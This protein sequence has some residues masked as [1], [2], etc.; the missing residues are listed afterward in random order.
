MSSTYI[1][2]S[3]DEKLKKKSAAQGE[4][5]TWGGAYYYPGDKYPSDNHNRFFNTFV[6]N[7]KYTTLVF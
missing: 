3:G 4:D 7:I 1:K 6:I 2:L 5:Y